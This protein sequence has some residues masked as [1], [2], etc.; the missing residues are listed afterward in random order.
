MTDK[1]FYFLIFTSSCLK[2]FELVVEPTHLSVLKNI[3]TGNKKVFLVQ[4]SNHWGLMF[5]VRLTNKTTNSSNSGTEPQL[6]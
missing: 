1:N 4:E 3:G 5:H 6:G 2:K